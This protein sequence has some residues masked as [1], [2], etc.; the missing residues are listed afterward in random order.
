MAVK[1]KQRSL[2]VNYLIIF[3]GGLVLLTLGVLV[4][5]MVVQNVY[6]NYELEEIL[7]TKENLETFAYE[8][9]AAVLYSVYTEN[10]LPEGSTWLSDN[11]DTWESFLKAIKIDF[12]FITDQDIELGEHRKYK[13]LI[14]PGAKSISDKQIIQIKK[15]LEEGGSVFT[16][17]GP[18]TFSDE[19]KWRGWEFFTEVFGMKFTKE[20]DPEEDRYKVHTLRGNIPLTAGI[21]S[22]Y[23]LRIATWDRPIYAEVLEPRT[24]QVSFWY[25]FRYEQG[26]VREQIRLST[27]IAHGTYGKGR[28]VWFGFELNSVIG[29]QEDYIYFDRLFR[30]SINWLTYKPTGYV[31]D[32]PDPFKAAMILTPEIKNQP[33][34]ILN[35][36][37][38]VNAPM[39]F[40]VDFETAVSYPGL[41]RSISNKGDFAAMVDVGVYQSTNDTLNIISDK[42]FQIGNISF[43]KDTLESILN[44]PL[45]G[46]SPTF[47]F[48]DEYTL[49]VLSEQDF[50][51]LITDSLTD[52]SVPKIEYRQNKPIMVVTRT[53]RDDYKVVRDYGLTQTNFQYYTYEEDVDRLLIEGGLYVMKLHTEYQLRPGY[54][55][56]V[57]DVISYARENNVWVTSIQELRDWWLRKGGVEVRYETRSKRRISVEI[58]NPTDS[59]IVDFVVEINLNKDVT[60]V[61][62]TSDIINTKIPRYEFNESNNTLYIYIELLEEGETRSYLVDFENVND[63][64][65]IKIF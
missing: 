43:V 1:N 31:K 54:V 13:L 16:S 10:M 17:G 63:E 15:F 7:P 51:F 4:F 33:G 56:V 30:N 9:K 28:F 5:L 59:P 19:A 46:I 37:S 45:K 36:T 58:S 61:N 50:E 34:N 39:T 29:K 35:L 11:I 55:N 12:D 3:L 8:E 21:P 24:E 27:G 53:A 25:D 64:Q 26:L 41:M 2:K 48:Y 14:L 18:A 57:N 23:T 38:T 6:G 52:R 40:L 49:Q 42:E 20:I 47:G 65:L 32:W 44:E 62:M 22:G 60:N